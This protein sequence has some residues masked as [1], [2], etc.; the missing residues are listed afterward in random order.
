MELLIGAGKSRVKKLH[1]AGQEDW[2]QLV[3]LDNNDEHEPDVVHDLEYF[4][5]PFKDNAFDEIHAYEVLEHTGAQG[6]FRFFFKQWEEFH[7]ILKPGG[8]FFGTVPKW[9]S[10]WAFGDP[11][12]R[13]VISHASLVFLSQAEYEKQVGKTPMSDFRFCYKGDFATELV[14]FKEETLEFVLK[15]IK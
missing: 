13:R 8:L 2:T 15:A 10:I 3:T 14:R 4:P 9:D 5:Y 1:I 7:R 11:S 12:H 6:D